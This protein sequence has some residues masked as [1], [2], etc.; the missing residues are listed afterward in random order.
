MEQY[1]CSYLTDGGM[2]L[3]L[4]IYNNYDEMRLTRM[5]PKSLMVNTAHETNKE[6]KRLFIVAAKDGNNS[7][8]NAC[9]A[10]IPKQ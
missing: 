3:V 5:Y 10:Y 4:F 8:F 1:V 2:L 9:R 7:A 6:R